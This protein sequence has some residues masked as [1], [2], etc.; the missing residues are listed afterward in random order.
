MDL[1]FTEADHAFRQE[2]QAFLAENLTDD[3][4]RA[5]R[6]TPTVFV[7]ADISVKWQK[8][9]AERGWGAP[10]WPQEFGGPGWSVSQRYIFNQECARADAPNPSPSGLQL[11]GP[12]IMKFGSD[13]QKEYFLPRII[14]GED[15]W[16]QGYS[17]PGSGSDL[18]ALKCK[19]TPDGEDY[20]VSGTK[21]WTTHA[22]YANWIFCLVRTSDTGKRQEGITFLLIPMD[23]AGISVRP[24][25][26]IGGDHEVNYVFFDDVR[27][28]QKYRVGEEGEGWT[29]AKYLLEWERGG[30]LFASRLRVKL[31]RLKAM[32][33]AEFGA[34]EGGALINDPHF[35][36]KLAAVEVDLTALEFSELRILSALEAGENPGP[37]SSILKIRQS[38]LTQD[39]AELA[40]EALG[41]NALPW[42]AE[43]PL[44]H[45]NEPPIGPDHA[46]P[47]VPAHLNARA[48]TIFG[49]STEI[50]KDIIA[51]LV[52]GL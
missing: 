36:H 52:L 13:W 17:E 44:Y 14:S 23:L 29:Y 24:I 15:Y 48:Y 40:V 49:G 33:R 47:V 34:A 51:K 2:V 20:I 35:A 3:L 31:D 4:K 43:R 16:C 8:A 10:S 37:I 30:G 6:E 19:A 11:V 38:Q 9:L 18:A 27:V 39:I 26:T 5:T 21:I 46:P 28:P 42:H 22:H 41:M 1:R 25:T 50:Q 7:E 12:V 32:A 45:R